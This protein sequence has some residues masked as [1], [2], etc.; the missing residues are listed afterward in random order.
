MKKTNILCLVLTLCVLASAIATV[1]LTTAAEEETTPA[2]EVFGR[3][4]PKAGEQAVTGPLAV[5]EGAKYSVEQYWEVYDEDAEEYIPFDGVFVLGGEYYGGLEVT[6]EED[7]EGWTFADE[8]D[9]VYVDLYVDGV[10]TESYWLWDYVSDFGD[11]WTVNPVI[12]VAE[13][14][15]AEIDRQAVGG[16]AT[17]PEGAEYTV[18]FIWFSEEYAGWDGVFA[19][20]ETYFCGWDIA[21]SEDWEGWA[22]ADEDGE[23]YVDLYVGDSYLDSIWVDED[24]YAW[25]RETFSFAPPVDR[26]DIAW[27]SLPAPGEYCYDASFPDI[28]INGGGE[29]SYSWLTE[30]FDIFDGD[31]VEDELYYLHLYVEAFNGLAEEATVSLNGKVLPEEMGYWDRVDWGMELRVPFICGREPAEQLELQ[32]APL[33]GKTAAEASVTV[34]GGFAVTQAMWGVLEDGMIDLFEGAFAEGETYYLV[35]LLG[36][37][38][39]VF[40]DYAWTDI[41]LNGNILPREGIAG[42]ELISTQDGLGVVIGCTVEAE[43]TTTQSTTSTTQ[44][45]TS[46]TQSTTS[47]TQ[48]TTTTAAGTVNEVET[49]TT[50]TTSSDKAPQSPSTGDTTAVAVPLM[51]V[52][53]FAA[54]ITLVVTNRK[55]A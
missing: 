45:T 32:V 44:S 34:S 43:G 50:T 31:F 52:A 53:L 35:A 21:V 16:S 37:P 13:A 22:L 49:N 25:F 17:V 2:I 7:W 23:V 9:E 18:E 1:A 39:A 5:P 19:D 40:A 20:G 26:V 6:V 3:Q 42:M 55:K 38:D 11:W 12:A 10:F 46:T 4:I 29:C 41:V 30:D 36:Q 14:P 48:S 27:E 33:A 15:V 28:E 47:T 51:L 54:G 8:D 24:G